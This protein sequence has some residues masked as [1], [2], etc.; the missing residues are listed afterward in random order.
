MPQRRRPDDRTYACDECRVQWFDKRRSEEPEPEN[1]LQT[2]VIVTTAAGPDMKDVHD[3]MPVII[4]A[5]DREKWLDPEQFE[6]DQV[7]GL[8]VP[9]SAGTLVRH[10]IDKAVNSVRNDG[11]E[12]IKAVA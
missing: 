9:S 2:C 12:I 7:T 1:Y 10:P 8:L 11:P 5:K 4:E 6:A 3:R